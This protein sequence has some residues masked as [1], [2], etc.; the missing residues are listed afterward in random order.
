MYPRE[1]G[2]CLTHHIPV[3]IV[4]AEEEGWQYDEE[5]AAGLEYLRSIK[6]D[7]RKGDFVIYDSVAGYRDG[8]T[9][10]FDGTKIINLGDFPDD[11]GSLPENFKVIEDGVPIDYWYGYG[12]GLHGLNNSFV[13]FNVDP[14]YS[15]C[16]D[17]MTVISGEDGGDHECRAKTTFVKDGETYT[18]VYHTYTDYEENVKECFSDWLKKEKYYQVDEDGK[19]TP[20]TL[21][22][23]VL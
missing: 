1:T 12:G 6:A 9:T 16:I 19:V 10:I 13:W 3:D 2:H 7:L 17:N 11:Y 20:N 23:F 18:I 15:Q 4:K 8:G 22:I 5:L 14:Y 21:H